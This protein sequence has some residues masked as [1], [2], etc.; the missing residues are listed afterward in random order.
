M[1]ENAFL[2]MLNGALRGSLLLVY[3]MA[4]RLLVR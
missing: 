4:F 2:W 1:L 3:I